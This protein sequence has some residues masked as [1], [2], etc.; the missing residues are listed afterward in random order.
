M[1]DI[2]KQKH[3]VYLHYRLATFTLLQLG[4]QDMT[5]VGQLPKLMQHSIKAEKSRHSQHNFS[6]TITSSSTISTIAVALLA[7]A[8]KSVIVALGRR[9]HQGASS[10]VQGGLLRLSNDVYRPDMTCFL[11]KVRAL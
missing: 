1:N 3:I 11:P 4:G 7:L 5:W 6:S 8:R 2:L 9:R 10:Q